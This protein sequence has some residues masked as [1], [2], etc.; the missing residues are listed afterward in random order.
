VELSVVAIHGRIGGVL[1][2][3]GDYRGAL[4]SLLRGI[5][6]ATDSSEEAAPLLNE[7]GGVYV[8]AGEPLQA[9]AAFADS[10]R[11]AGES[12]ALR[13]T[14]GINLARVLVEAGVAGA[15][16]DRVERLRRETLA[17]PDSATKAQAFLAI[18]TLLRELDPS[19]SARDA[20]QV[21]AREAAAAALELARSFGDAQLLALAYGE[22]GEWHF[23][24]GQLAEALSL[25]RLATVVAQD[26][27]ASEALYRAE[28]LSGRILRTMGRQPEARAAYRAAVA[29][30]AAAQAPLVTSE[31]SF[32]MDVLPL[33]T[34]YADV[35]LAATPGIAPAERRETL[36]EVRQTLE[37]LRLAEVLNYFENQCAV[38]EVFDVRA[39]QVAD[40]VVIYPVIFADRTELLVS[41]ND[42][43]FQFT[44]P[45]GLDELTAQALLLRRALEAA[46]SDSAYLAPAQRIYRW[47]IQPLLPVIEQATPKALVIVPAGPLRTVPLAVLHDGRQFLI[48]RYPLATT[49][50]ASLIA[51]GASPPMGRVLAT[52]LVDSVQGFPALPFVAAELAS[53]AETFP[54]RVYVDEDF[55]SATVQREILQGGYAIVHLATHAQFESDYQRSFLLTY[56][57]LITMDEL[58]ELMSGQRLSTQPVDLLVLSAC[59]TAAGDERAALGLAGVAVKAGARSALASLWQINDESTAGLIAEF[60]RQLGSRNGKAAA[61]RGA[62]LKL[63]NDERYRHPAY[64]APFLLI[65]DWR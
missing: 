63:M 34:E 8:A 64:W 65:G 55:Q 62:Q 15:F 30:L 22:L 60:Y 23:A 46:D 45:V 3:L 44:A 18:A 24:H 16:R 35:T 7:L 49:P 28:W 11:L 58:E 59:Q 1:A 40:A 29:S 25:A 52:G 57:D 37:R 54:A 5:E 19:A 38:P 42:N 17:L 4:E 32:R 26:G 50:A 48:E 39:G 6:L 47:L 31:R 2:S 33:Y 56:D 12:A 41:T 27:V 9:V 53:V 36:L 20:T 61:L 10:Y 13:I 51:T 14:S 21:R 43:V